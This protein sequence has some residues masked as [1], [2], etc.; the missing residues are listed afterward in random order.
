VTDSRA[1]AVAL[2][3]IVV[4]WAMLTAVIRWLILL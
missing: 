4:G 1:I 3:V 2:V